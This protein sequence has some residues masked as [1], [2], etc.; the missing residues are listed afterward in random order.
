MIATQSAKSALL[1]LAVVCTTGLVV[2]EGSSRQLTIDGARLGM[3][4][5]ELLKTW[6]RPQSIRLDHFYV[7][8]A[9]NHSIQCTRLSWPKK[10]LFRKFACFEAGRVLY[11]AGPSVEEQGQ[12]LGSFR[13]PV[14]KLT[15]L[16]GPGES[17]SL[18]VWG[19]Y[20]AWSDRH[21]QV[22]KIGGEFI[23]QVALSR[24]L[25]FPDQTPSGN[26]DVRLDGIPLGI[27]KDEVALRASK[28]KPS[29]MQIEYSSSGYTKRLTAGRELFWRYVTDVPTGTTLK[30]G[31]PLKSFDGDPVAPDGSTEYPDKGLKITMRK[32]IVADFEL[33]L[34]DA[35]MWRALDQFQPGSVGGDAQRNEQ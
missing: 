14:S 34:K 13:D 5:D 29:S 26:L 27:Q 19:E 31:Q 10:E 28:Q 30:V 20:H 24:I 7:E 17:V 18:S 21:L 35:E 16:F 8:A 1:L 32:G 15:D 23:G 4:Y 2:G 9:A 12:V 11:C 25:D 3:S 6:G 33:E 22:R